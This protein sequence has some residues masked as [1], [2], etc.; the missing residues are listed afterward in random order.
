M[1]FL[2]LLAGYCFRKRVLFLSLG[3]FFFMFVFFPPNSLLFPLLILPVS[4][5]LAPVGAAGVARAAL[6]RASSSA[7][8]QPAELSEHEVPFLLVH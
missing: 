1:G 5:S 6:A 3:I 2:D 7:T 8:L 4:T